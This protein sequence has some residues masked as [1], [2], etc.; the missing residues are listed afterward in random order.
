MKTIMTM[1]MAAS[2]AVAQDYLRDCLYCKKTDEDAYFVDSYS[3]CAASETC[4]TNAWNYLDYK[5]ESGW[6]RG[7][8]LSLESCQAQPTSRECPTFTSMQMLAGAQ[9]TNYTWTLQ[10]GQYCTVKVDANQFVGR[11]LFSDVTGLGIDTPGVAVGREVSFQ[12]TTG[13]IVLYNGKQTRSVTFTISF[14]GAST[15]FASA[16]ALAALT[17]AAF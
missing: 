12:G 11:V 17:L 6:K 1:A 7:S 10:T 16:T 5:C 15:L 9:R 13:E 14:S 3:Y 8:S 2:V 4:L